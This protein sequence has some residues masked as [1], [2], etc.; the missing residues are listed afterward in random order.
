MGFSIFKKQS[1]KKTEESTGIFSRLKTGLSKTRQVLTTDINDLFVS[2]KTIDEVR[3]IHQTIL[4]EGAEKMIL[5]LKPPAMGKARVI[6]GSP[7]I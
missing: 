5:T 6:N 3:K 2:G 4:E 7:G 1:S